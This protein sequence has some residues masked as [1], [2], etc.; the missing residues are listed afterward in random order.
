MSTWS[1]V[2]KLITIAASVALASCDQS[3][4][5]QCEIVDLSQTAPDWQVEYFE[6]N[7]WGSLDRVQACRI[8]SYF[9][10]ASEGATTPHLF[11][12]SDEG[13]VAWIDRNV[14]ISLFEDDRPLLHLDDKDN[15]GSYD[16]LNYDVYNT[17]SSDYISVLDGDLDGQADSRTEHIKGEKPRA[18]LWFEGAWRPIKWLDA[19]NP[20]Q[21]LVDGVWRRY[22]R[23]DGVLAL[24]DDE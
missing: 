21:I 4:A 14:G 15:D 11:I 24:M 1:I 6:E 12:R 3:A 9:V 2:V 17:G 20:N 8:G 5:P 16:W 10:Y 22:E 7:G 19:P 13:P 23:V 18:W